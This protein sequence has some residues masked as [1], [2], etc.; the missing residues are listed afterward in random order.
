MTTNSLAFNALSD[1]DLLATVHR[2]A[3]GERQA[4]TRLIALLAELDA[5]RLYLSEGYSSLFTYC[6]QAL[7][8]SEHAAYGRIEAARAARAYPVVLECLE[9]GD[10]TLTTIGLLAPHLT[11]DNHR[12]L[13]DAARHKSKREVE[14]LVA[15]LRPQPPA[16]SVIRKLPDRSPVRIETSAAAPHSAAPLT[17]PPTLAPTSNLRTPE[18]EI[19]P[20]VV[21]PVDAEHYKVQFT[22]T[23]ETLDKL[24]RVQ[25]L[26]RHTCPDLGCRHRLR[27]R[28]AGASRPS[29]ADETGASLASARTAWRGGNQIA[30]YSGSGTTCRLGTR[31]G[32]VRVRWQARSMH[33][34]RLSRV[35]SRAA[36]RGRRSWRR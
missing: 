27:T 22:I 2:V 20:A 34:A 1:R 36:V 8:L 9:A 16:P 29:G 3:L 32:T 15:T 12:H 10:I 6:T 35:S 25:D 13:L 24:R 26:I 21:K 18:R 11:P 30:T 33:G 5:R 14:H 31:R 23:R 19:R 28:L 17:D 7:R 4:T